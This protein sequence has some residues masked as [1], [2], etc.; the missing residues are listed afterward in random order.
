MPGKKP[1]VNRLREFRKSVRDKMFAL[2]NSFGN[3]FPYSNEAVRIRRNGDNILAVDRQTGVVV[4]SKRLKEAASEIAIVERG[5][6]QV[7][8]VITDRRRGQRRQEDDPSKYY[9]DRRG[10][11]RVERRGKSEGYMDRPAGPEERQGEPPGWR[12]LV[13]IDRKIHKGKKV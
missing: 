12:K 1:N 4:D 13:E 8:R 6:G 7:V 10:K 11:E 2:K 5:S 3:R 9:Y